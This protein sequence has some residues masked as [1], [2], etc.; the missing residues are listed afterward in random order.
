MHPTAPIRGIE[1]KGRP[2]GDARS[3]AGVPFDRNAYATADA[4]VLEDR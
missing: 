1:K 3:D 4:R 2:S